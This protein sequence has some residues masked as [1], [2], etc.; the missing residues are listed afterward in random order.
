MADRSAIPLVIVG[1]G[2][3]GLAAAITA[4][5]LLRQA[6]LGPVTVL[7]RL[8][9]VGKKLLATGN[10]RCN[11]THAEIDL[12]NY[13]GQDV[14]FALGALRRFDNEAT[15]DF[16]RELGML[17]RTE[18]DGRV[19]PYS[20]QANTVLDTLRQA[21]ADLAIDIRTGFEVAE[22]Q[23]AEPLFIG[24]EPLN[25]AAGFEIF[26]TGR[27]HVHARK[28]ILAAGGCASPAL[29][30]DGSGFRL[31]TALG[32][33]LVPPL[34]SIVQIT[35]ETT[36]TKPLTGIKVQGRARLYEGQTEIASEYGEI[37]FTE[38]GLS[39]PPILQLARPISERMAGDS[40]LA[41]GGRL[42]VVLD[43]M[44]E[45]DETEIVSMLAEFSAASASLTVGDV[46][47]GL[48]H[49]KVAQTVVRQALQRPMTE[50]ARSMSRNDR[51]LVA[52]MVKNLPFRV[53]GTRGFDFAQ[54]TAGGIATEGFRPDTLESKRVPGLYAAGE[55]LDIDGDCGGF[56]LQW[57][58][59]S[60]VL[61]GRKAAEALIREAADGGRTTAMDKQ[62]RSAVKERRHG[63]KP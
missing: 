44:P 45:F 50:I 38:Y 56:N 59:A 10:G 3:S 35:T 21:A 31:L 52:A 27:E 54:A 58:W 24:N 25:E 41:G 48:L 11:L 47:N 1:G 23:Q 30:S 55:V 61:A 33:T 32:H 5:R 12:A 34:P 4:A 39:G 57:A 42:H 40:V 36:L 13:H 60:G 49:K 46:L 16:F 7:E 28:V 20:L 18:D 9:R 63:G 14:R 8:D 26:S 29:G 22:I 53:T 19:F 43:L 6:R 62:F 37:L 2:A 15:I 17:C 51:H